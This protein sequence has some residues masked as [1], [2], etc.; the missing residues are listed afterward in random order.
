[1]KELIEALKLRKKYNQMDFEDFVKEFEEFLGHELDKK[2][3]DRF[4]YN[5]L[6]NTDFLLMNLPDNIEY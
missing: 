6:H 1:M 3:K 2:D 5:G 4:Y